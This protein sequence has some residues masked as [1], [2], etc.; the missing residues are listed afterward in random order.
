MNILVVSSFL[1]YPLFSGGH[2]RLYNILKN[3]SKTHSIYL[4]CEIRDHQTPRDVDEVKKI[5]K[6]VYTVK[7]KKQWSIDTIIK[8]AFSPHPFLLV[9]HTSSQMKKI[10][11]TLLQEKKI[12]IIHVE[13]FYV[14]QNL[15]STEVPIVLVEHNIEYLVYKRFVETAPFI[16]RSLLN[17]DIHK[18]KRA[19]EHYWNM[20]T[21]IVAVSEEERQLIN[22]DNISVVPNGV[23]VDK[24]KVQSSKLKDDSVEK[25]VLF[26][27]DFKWIQNKKAAEWI[28]KDIW[29]SFV[30][31]SNGKQQAKLW[32]VG[33]DI[34]DSIRNLTKDKNVIFDENAP[35]ETEKIFEQAN[36]LISP[37]KVGGGT[38]FKILEAMASGAIVITTRLGIEGI[39]A[40]DNKEVLLAETTEDFVENLKK[41][42]NEPKLYVSIMQN[43]RKLIEEQYDW[44]NIVGKL[45]EVYRK[46]VS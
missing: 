34:P 2:V 22:K 6:E 46:H 37:V 32:I 36:I 35:R 42:L 12:D 28:L 26:I 1:P 44:K 9:G 29:P 33:R 38:S 30:K 4:V 25:K 43:A 24:F 16:V 17:L 19:E 11:S 20:A 41:I 8:T 45:E 21:E 14:F 3:L 40:F 23:D 18:L 5:C 31:S 10:I 27:G 13:T 39:K 15:P 7:R